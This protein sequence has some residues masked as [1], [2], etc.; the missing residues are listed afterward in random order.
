MLSQTQ[1]HLG[2]YTSVHSYLA[3]PEVKTPTKGF[4]PE[5]PCSRPLPHI[6][7]YH[8]MRL[9]P[10]PDPTHVYGF[11][12]STE[13][14]NRWGKYFYEAGLEERFPEGD[15][16]T[17]EV[18]YDMARS[19]IPCLLYYEFPALP[20]FS[21]VVRFCEDRHSSRMVFVLRDNA[22]RE[23]RTAH[24]LRKDVE[25]V[26]EILGLGDQMPKWYSVTW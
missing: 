11:V 16:N 23:R 14:L 24:L 17:L 8:A 22:S 6:D 21:N 20:R 4:I 5:S 10:S 1:C 2:L 7:L 18:W 9:R 3:M 15:D 26:R 12:L 19:Y 13:C 25:G